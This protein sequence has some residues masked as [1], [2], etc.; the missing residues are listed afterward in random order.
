MIS[1]YVGTRN[2]RFRV[3]S[4][5]LAIFM[6][7]TFSL[8]APVQAE[9]QDWGGNGSPT[10]CRGNWTVKSTP[11]YGKR[12]PTRGKVIGYLDIRWSNTCHGN[13]S[14]VRLWGGMY[15]SSVTI[16][17]VVRSEGK[18]AGAH[19]WFS[20]RQMK[21]TGTH[22]WTPYVRLKSSRSIAC[23]D[24]WV[25]SDFGTLNFHTT[26]ARICDR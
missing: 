12:G 1:S 19:D 4:I 16:E 5:L 21:T 20:A 9:A 10:R 13:W 8:V 18:S 25:S 22:A 23:V 24:A 6:T 15:A 2:G 14:R 26:G 11:L 17:Q 7:A 3:L